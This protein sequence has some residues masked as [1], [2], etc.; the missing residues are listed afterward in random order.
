[1]KVLF[2]YDYGK[3]KMDH[4][5]SLGCEIILRNEKGLVYDEG[6]AGAEVLVC[7]NPFDTLDLEKLGD[8]KLILLSSIGVDQVPRQ[9]VSERGIILTNNKG[10]YSVPIGEW[11]VLKV[12]EMA[13]NSR[14]LERQQRELKWKMDTNVIEI[15]GMKV[16][17]LGTG[18]LAVESAKR[19]QGFGLHITGYN[20]SGTD[21]RYFDK[22][23]K[24]SGFITDASEYDIVV[25]T[26]PSTEHTRHFISDKALGAMKQGCMLVNVS[27]G[28]IIDE[29]A[30][31]DHSAKFRG[32]ALDVFESEP[33]SEYSPLWKLENVYIS[34]HNSWISQMRNERRFETIYENL[35]RYMAGQ[36]LINIVD[37]KKGY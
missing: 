11:V 30:L 3:E 4:I 33:L 17:F 36:E 6:M 21:A 2:T 7:Y 32:I 24:L 10:G 19:L 31:I 18:T 9:H 35:K 20:T 22:C 14:L 8:L 16:A 29:R 26:L 25:S 1:M 13:K 37:L 27:R 28:D 5:E 34:P 23:R 15:F 12:L